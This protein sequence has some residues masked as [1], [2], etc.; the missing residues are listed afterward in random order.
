[1]NY[2]CVWSYYC[3]HQLEERLTVERVVSYCTFQ[4]FFVMFGEQLCPF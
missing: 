2:G 1:M 3:C 4:T